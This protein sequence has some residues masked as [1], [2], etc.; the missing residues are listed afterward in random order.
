MLGGGGLYLAWSGPGG[1]GEGEGGGGGRLESECDIGNPKRKS[2]ISIQAES[3][4]GGV[5]E[6]RS[7]FLE[8]SLGCD[9]GLWM[10]VPAMGSKSLPSSLRGGVILAF[11]DESMRLKLRGL[12]GFVRGGFGGGKAESRIC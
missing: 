8:V 5:R 6:I 11:L 4:G 1:V 10:K 9:F 2:S 12:R 7:G 3:S